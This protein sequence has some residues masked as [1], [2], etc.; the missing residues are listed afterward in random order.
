ML[1]HRTFRSR[2]ILVKLSAALVGAALAFGGS[3]APA[4]TPDASPA[5]TNGQPTSLAVAVPLVAPAG[6]T[7]LI[8]ADDL[9]SYTTPTGEL[10]RQLNAVIG[11]P[12]AIGVDPMIV[13]SIRILGSEAPESALA[14]LER[15]RSAGNETFALG[16]ADS[17]IAALSQAGAVGILGP[18]GFPIDPSL[19]PEGDADGEADG[20]GGGAGS[21]DESPSASPS[22]SAPGEPAVPTPETLVDLPYSLGPI[23]WPR[24]NTVRDADLVNFS[25]TGPV[26]TILGSSNVSSDRD[27]VQAS[28]GVGDSAVLVSHTEISQLLRTTVTATSDESWLAALAELTLALTGWTGGGSVLATLDRTVA[29]DTTRIGATIDALVA[30]TDVVLATLDSA[31]AEPRAQVS[32]IDPV[33]DAQ[34]VSQLAALLATEPGLA[35]FATVLDDPSLLT[36]PRRLA[37][38]ALSST[39]WMSLPASWPGSVDDYL[40]R[41]AELI[42]SV[43]VEESST[44]N[45]RSF[46]GNLPIMVSNAL[47]YP[48]TVY[49][50][51]TANTAI[52]DILE[53]RVPVVVEAESQARAL[54]PVQSIANGDVLLQVSLSSAMNVPV[55]TPIFISTNVQAEWETAFTLVV[56]IALFVI[57]VLGFIRTVT[58]RRRQRAALPTAPEAAVPAADA[59]PAAGRVAE[60]SADGDA[61]G[62][63][64]V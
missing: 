17:D 1:A 46:T 30:H 28:A 37:I 63:Q 49:V 7:G 40:Q 27:H 10:T 24:E 48:A 35:A 55:S 31:M 52:L 61:E 16:Y 9:L 19:F 18:T 8:P 54:V 43:R 6:T 50:T 44:L 41:H 25:V 47:P 21:I 59:P 33:P 23:A 5:A 60:P 29:G 42:N 62:G 34:R 57:F 14:W 32:V 38:L 13:A 56:V 15:L 36:G 2:P 12:V 64:G 58:R 3:A 51:V 20:N 39:A 45:L 22:P 4:V 11:R 53:S 26:T